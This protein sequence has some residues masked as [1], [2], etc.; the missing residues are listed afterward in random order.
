MDSR[1]RNFLMACAVLMVQPF[2][3]FYFP[4]IDEPIP[5]GIRNLQQW[6]EVAWDSGT[7]P[8]E[9]CA[10][11][12][13]KS[14]RF[15]SRGQAA[16]QEASRYTQMDRYIRHLGCL[17]FPRNTVSRSPYIWFNYANQP[18]FIVQPDRNWSTSTLPGQM[19]SPLPRNWHL[20]NL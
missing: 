6:I 10:T 7:R 18:P 5:P 17:L 11:L 19:V 13:Q 9:V 8:V 1:Y 12:T 16:A 4:L 14:I 15:R 2:E 20:G 3:P